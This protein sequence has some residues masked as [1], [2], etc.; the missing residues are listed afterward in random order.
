[1]TALATVWV[2][3][4]QLNRAIGALAEATPSAHRVLLITATDK[5]ESR[6]WHPAR[7]SLITRAIEAFADDLRGEGFIVDHRH[8]ASMRDGVAAHRAEFSPSR[9]IVT[10]PNSVAAR[11]L[12][13]SLDC[14]VVKSNQFLCHPSEF[15]EWAGTR[16]S[17][18]ME[19][20]YRWQRRR[21]GY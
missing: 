6:P 14:E 8:A 21:T 17:F 1:M 3:G 16:K 5:I 4:D 20:F 10:E 7:I 11:S 15:D 9:L 19:D 18:K 13:K 2:F 12:V